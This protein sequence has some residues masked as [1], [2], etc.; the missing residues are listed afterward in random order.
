MVMDKVL[1][2]GAA[3]GLGAGDAGTADG[4]GAL[5]SSPLF[6]QFLQENSQFAWDEIIE[7]DANTEL[8]EDKFASL[9]QFLDALAARTANLCT[10]KQPFV[11]IG[12]D[13]SCAIGTWSGV[14]KCRQTLGR[15]G[16][17]WVDAHLDAHTHETSESGNVHGMPV[18]ALLGRGDPRLTGMMFTGPKLAAEHFALVGIRSFEQAE[19]VTLKQLGVDIYYM[20]DVTNEGLTSV[21]HKSLQV[22]RRAPAGF[23]LSVDLDGFD[24]QDAPGVGTPVGNGIVVKEFCDTVRGLAHDP[25]FCGLEITEFNPHLDKKDKS[26]QTVIDIIKAVYDL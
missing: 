9:C 13:H 16:M 19:V 6:I 11:V 25:N 26:V 7:A 20:Q 5:H 15:M 2:I 10:A 14:A 8:V 4:P 3:C 1:L 18:A 23:C 12:G 17:I 22:V 24:P 21:M